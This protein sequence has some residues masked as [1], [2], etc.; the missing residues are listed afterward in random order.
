MR[1][2]ESE[3]ERGGEGGREGE[4]ELYPLQDTHFNVLCE[5]PHLCC[6][7]KSDQ[8]NPVGVKISV[9]M[10]SLYQIPFTNINSATRSFFCRHSELRV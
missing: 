7:R 4:R 10:C 9:C 6:S 2:R 8:V 3:R 1:E 5:V